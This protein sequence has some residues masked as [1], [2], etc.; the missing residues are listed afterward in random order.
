M[1]ISVRVRVRVRVS[2]FH[3]ARLK[4]IAKESG[5]EASGHGFEATISGFSELL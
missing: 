2:D 3:I 4:V 5:F 1:K